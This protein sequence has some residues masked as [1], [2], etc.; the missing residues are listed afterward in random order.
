M[1]RAHHTRGILF[2]LLAGILWGALG[3]MARVA[4]AEGMAPLDV[5]FWRAVIGWGF[6]L[7]HAAS[8][9]ALK[10]D[11]RDL[12]LV[13]LFALVSVSGFYGSYQLAVRYGGA[14]R[15][16]VLLYTAPAWVAI[17]A[18]LFLRESLSPRILV[19]VLV[20]IVGVAVISLSGTEQ[21]EA[22]PQGILFGLISGFTYALY[23]ILGRRLLDR[24]RSIT[25]FFWI[26]PIGAV[27]LAPFVSFSIPSLPAAAALLGIGFASTYL[28]YLVYAAGL[29]YLRSSQ[30]AVV[31]TIEPVAAVLMAFAFWGENLGGAGY[32]GALLVVTSVL[33]QVQPH[34]PES[35]PR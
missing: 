17:M 15:A 4:L 30:A 33:L 18:V 35:H 22:A 1:K 8:R 25:L 3:S 32:V 5:A 9:R 21:G 19:G 29:R 6:F 2:I 7:A 26:L 10:I 23:Y 31:A 24:Y 27:G 14:A 20:S 12:P 16:S 11:R 28:A 34:R 13:A